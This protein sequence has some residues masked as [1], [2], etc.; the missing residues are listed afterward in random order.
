MAIE[1]DRRVILRCRDGEEDGYRE[2][3]ARYERYVYSL[4]FRLTGSREDALDLTQET[5]IRVLRGL[6]NFE[7]HRPFKPWLRRVAVRLCLNHLRDEGTIR[8]KTGLSLQHPVGEEL[9]LADTLASDADPAQEVEWREL[10]RH[11]WKTVG[12][13]PPLYR[14]VVTLRHQEGMSY[15]EIAEAT[16]LP[17]GTVKTYLF[18]ARNKL[19]QE[20]AA[21]YGWEV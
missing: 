13:L 21:V 14:L 4:C 2:L 5:F 12:R 7:V 8:A 10:H 16:D 11:L 15:Q 20:L 9:T 19:K 18:R 1:D 3:I 17:V 6:D